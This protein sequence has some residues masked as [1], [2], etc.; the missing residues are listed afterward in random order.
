L[1]WAK[2]IAKTE[3]VTSESPSLTRFDDLAP[4]YEGWFATRLGAF[5]ARREEEL[6]LGLLSPMPGEFILEVGSG[7]DYFLR[8]LARSGARCVGVEPAAEMLAAA[9]TQPSA[10]IEHVR[11]CGESLPFKDETFDGLLYMTALEFVQ[12][13]GAALA[14]A[15]RVVRPGGHLVFGVLNAEGPWARSRKREG[16]LWDEAHF[17]R[18]R[19]LES[20]LTPLG[21]VTTDFCVHIPPQ[22]GWLPSS[23]MSAVDRLSRSLFPASAALIGARVVKGRPQ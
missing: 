9:L 17:Y 10:N 16:G 19:E 1:R 21:A 22:L 12:D 11:G 5:V 20:L 18:A 4:A 3:P 14:E 23:V 15:W 8:P 2:W 13:V 7:T 6:I